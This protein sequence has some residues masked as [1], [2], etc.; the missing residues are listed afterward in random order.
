MGVWCDG[1]E[2]GRVG[3]REGWMVGGREGERQGGSGEHQGD[4]GI[5][6]ECFYIH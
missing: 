1:L 2:V 5:V 4:S 3:G 6:M